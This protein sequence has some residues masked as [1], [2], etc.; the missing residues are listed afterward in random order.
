MR[1]G[2]GGAEAGR[3]EVRVSAEGARKQKTAPRTLSTLP[4]TF[5]VFLP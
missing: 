1:L 2:N 5:G 3:Q 4:A